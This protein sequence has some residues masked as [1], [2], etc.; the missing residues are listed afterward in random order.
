MASNTRAVKARPQL[1]EDLNFNNIV[2]RQFDKAAETLDL[3]E[4]LLTQIKVCNNIFYVQFPVRTGNR[5][6]PCREPSRRCES[7]NRRARS[8]PH[9]GRCV[10]RFRHVLDPRRRCRHA[11]A[12]PGGAD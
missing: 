4:T 2:S 10:A 11:C 12:R 6:L 5:L 7:A 3:P 8:P 9:V 1:Q